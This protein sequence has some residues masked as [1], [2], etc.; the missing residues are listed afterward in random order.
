MIMQMRVS[1]SSLTCSPVQHMLADDDWW[2]NIETVLFRFVTLEQSLS[3]ELIISVA[4]DNVPVN[5]VNYNQHWQT[6]QQQILSSFSSHFHYFQP[7]RDQHC[8]ESTNQRLRFV[9]IKNQRSAFFCASGMV[10]KIKYFS[11]NER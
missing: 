10:L 2:W 3:W 4:G 5:Q 1:S 7:I 6:Q 11:M 8:L 9:F